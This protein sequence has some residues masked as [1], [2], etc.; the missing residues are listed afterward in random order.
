MTFLNMVKIQL[1]SHEENQVKT[2]YEE[3]LVAKVDYN[4]EEIKKL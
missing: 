3:Q 2:K 4:E 1:E